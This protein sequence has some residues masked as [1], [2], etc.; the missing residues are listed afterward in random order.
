VDLLGSLVSDAVQNRTAG[1][2]VL[3]W[4]SKHLHWNF[5]ATRPDVHEDNDRVYA[6]AFK[7]FAQHVAGSEQLL[8]Y[9]NSTSQRMIRP[10]ETMQRLGQTIQAA[11]AVPA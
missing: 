10:R 8:D 5:Q 7:L 11:V 4:I 3:D 2:D 6:V 1:E 9:I